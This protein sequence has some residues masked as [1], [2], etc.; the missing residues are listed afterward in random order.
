MVM[1]HENSSAIRGDSIGHNRAM[2]RISLGLGLLK[3]ESQDCIKLPRSGTA[4]H[5]SGIKGD[6]TRGQS[7]I[8]ELVGQG[9]NLF[10]LLGQNLWEIVGG[11]KMSPSTNSKDLKKWKVRAGKVMYA[12]SISVE[13]EVLQRIKDAKTPKKAWNTLVELFAWTNDAKLQQLENELL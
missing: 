9:P 2:E 12:L 5:R 3:V 6:S 1:E 8:V 13:D 11:A 7:G 4:S 10:Y